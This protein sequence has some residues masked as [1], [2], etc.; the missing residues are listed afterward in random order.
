VR[1][2]PPLVKKLHLERVEEAFHG[3]VD[4]P[5][6]SSAFGSARGAEL[7]S[8]DVAKDLALHVPLKAAHDIP[9]RPTFGEALRNVGQRWRMTAHT[10]DHD[11]VIPAVI[12][13]DRREPNRACRWR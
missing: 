6:S 7:W 3:R 5:M 9:L 12:T 4:A 1:G 8:A 11:P 13:I 10:C 2:P